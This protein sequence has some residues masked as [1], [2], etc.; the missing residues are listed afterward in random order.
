MTNEVVAGQVPAISENSIKGSMMLEMMRA[1]YQRMVDE[2]NALEYTEENLSTI[3]D[4]I[5][6]L[7]GVKKIIDKTHA[8]GKAQFLAICRMF[9]AAKNSQTKMVDDILA[10][11]TRRY[12]DM[13]RAI[14]TRKRLE[15][16][17][18]RKEA[19]LRA[20]IEKNLSHFAN[21]VGAA[22]T[23]RDLVAIEKAIGTEKS[24]K[25]KYGKFWDEAQE[26][27]DSLATLI[28]QQKAKITEAEKL[29]KQIEAESK[30]EDVDLD[31][32]E[33]NRERLAEVQEN[34][35]EGAIRAQEGA[36]DY[37][38]GAYDTT[39]AV[40]EAFPQVKPKRSVWKWEVVDIKLTAKKMPDWVTLEPNED[41]IE[42]YLKA[43]KEEG[44]QTEEFVL[45]GIRFYLS[46]T[47]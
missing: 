24:R 45:A 4:T 25:D 21:L 38:T 20:G 8:D 40:R 30:K 34:I 31:A 43:K 29:A 10:E 6:K 9:D 13:C 18:L 26:R 17:A 28:K 11:P 36:I 32:L 16:E 41:V 47:Y 2:V 27:Y 1:G 7:R 39:I 33:A 22:K 44:I 23:A 12:T 15:E 3:A 35:S 37:A 5:T 46:K 14:E 42:A 19:E